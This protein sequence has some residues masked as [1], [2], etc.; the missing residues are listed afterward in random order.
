M[1]IERLEKKANAI[2]QEHVNPY[3]VAFSAATVLGLIEEIKLLRSKSESAQ[4]LL[5]EASEQKPFRWFLADKVHGSEDMLNIPDIT[6]DDPGRYTLLPMYLKSFPASEVPSA[7]IDLV[8]T[9]ADWKLPETG[10]FWDDDPTRPMSYGS[11]WG[12]NG[13]RDFMRGV[14]HEAL[15]FVQPKKFR[16]VKYPSGEGLLI[17]EDQDVNGVVIVQDMSGEYRRVA[18]NAITII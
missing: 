6:N 15:S 12:S 3:V 9:I 8:K 7:F 4:S 5:K 16:R 1:D 14:A 11:L 10:R 2:T 18:R 17:V 13:E